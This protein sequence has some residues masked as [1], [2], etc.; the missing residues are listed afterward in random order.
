MESGCPLGNVQGRQAQK[1]YV[2][3]ST[4]TT[5]IIRRLAG[6][7]VHV[8]AQRKGRRHCS[9]TLPRMLRVTAAVRPVE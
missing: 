2:G 1:V 3:G 5:L 7:V 9:T 4:V 8:L 6:T